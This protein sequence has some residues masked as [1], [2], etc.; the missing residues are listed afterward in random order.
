MSALASESILIAGA[1]GLIGSRL[2]EALRERGHD[3]AHLSR[4]ARKGPVRTYVW[5]PQSGQIDA[6][7]VAGR[8]VVINLSGANI[9]GKRWSKA[10]KQEIRDS[11]VQSG[12]LLRRAIHAD[13][14]HVHTYISASGVSIYGDRDGSIVLTED[15]LPAGD[16]LAQVTVAWE[17]E[18][19][20]IGR[21]GLRVVKLRTGPVLSDDGG[22]LESFARP[23]RWF[24]GAPL[25]TG[26]QYISWIHI[27]DICNMYAFVVEN[28]NVE[29]TFNA[30]A[31]GPVTNREFTRSIARA[32][33]RP[34]WL[35]PV[36]GFVLRLIMGE[37]AFL[38]VGGCR[39]S[40]DKIMEAGFAFKFS[41]LAK[42]M[43][44]IF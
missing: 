23:V 30:T 12:A 38:A 42:A 9:G 37:M 20:R 36:P 32:L 2:S 41:T 19:D 18:A 21:P 26:D 13:G 1:S 29:G 7:A 10:Y 11:R 16:F 34:L 6:D 5:D 4:R 40:S 44:D 3:V 24:V 27:D 17:N 25:G 8:T 43:N 39:V 35:P 14:R 22:L 28:G 33:K 31:P 15:D